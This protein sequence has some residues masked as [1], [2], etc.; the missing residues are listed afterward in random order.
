MTL[1]DLL[2]TGQAQRFYRIAVSAYGATT[3]RI[4]QQPVSQTNYA[5]LSTTFSVYALGQQPI[6]Y[7]W[8][9]AGTDIPGATANSLTLT[10]LSTNDAGSYS[11]TVSNAGGA[12]LSTPATLTVLPIPTNSPDLPGLVLHLT[13]DNTLTDATGRGNNGTAIHVTTS[14]SNATTA[15][16]VG[17]V[18]GSALHY[19]SDFGVFPCCTTTN[20][21]YVT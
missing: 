3:P 11:V 20:T 2:L 17:G 6:S 9:K 18:V 21:F 13:F 4:I 1:T 12:L 8:S 19:S 15:T 7:Q 14:S 5:S 16:F 10:P